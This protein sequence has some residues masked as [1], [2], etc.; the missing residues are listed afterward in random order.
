MYLAI[1]FIV[2]NT[3][4]FCTSASNT[5]NSWLT[6]LRFV[7]CPTLLIQWT[8]YILARILGDKTY[9]DRNIFTIG[10]QWQN[11]W[12]RWWWIRDIYCRINLMQ[13]WRLLISINWISSTKEMNPITRKSMS[14]LVMQ[15]SFRAVGQTLVV[16]FEK[17]ENKRQMYGR[18]NANAKTYNIF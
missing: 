5:R 13:I 14:K 12:S 11:Q 8:T 9:P 7:E 18:Q 1:R 16:E 17:L 10:A 6:I 15:P 4:C 2:L 3:V